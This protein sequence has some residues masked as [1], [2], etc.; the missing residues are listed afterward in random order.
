MKTLRARAKKVCLVGRYG[1]GETGDEAA[2]AGL[3]QAFRSTPGGGESDL[4]LT[5]LSG[6]P[7]TTQAEHDIRALHRCRLDAVAAS[8]L[9]ATGA[10]NVFSDNDKTHSLFYCL[11]LMRAAQILGKH[12]MIAAA[13]IGP[14]KRQSSAA[15]LAS[16]ARGC[17]AITVTDESSSEALAK[18]GVQTPA[19]LVAADPAILLGSGAPGHSVHGAS[20]SLQ[21][22]PDAPEDFA[23][24][25][26]RICA[27]TLEL[28]AYQPMPMDS[29]DSAVIDQF[30]E[31]ANRIFGYERPL[32]LRTDPLSWQDLRQ[33][34]AGSGLVIAMRLHALIL[35]A[36]SGVPSVA[37]DHDPKVRAF[38]QLSGQTDTVVCLREV[39]ADGFRNAL[40]QAWDRKEETATRL[41]DL[42]PSLCRSARRTAEIAVSAMNR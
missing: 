15:L 36:A 10:G 33:R 4:R 27:A 20:I 7:K 40:A 8:D 11:G 24:V 17:D 6:R 13:G 41:R 21:Q 39:Y 25:I 12:T 35:A 26:G 37:L 38:M 5:A 29:R 3:V 9:V 19:P 18:I 32:K 22:W 14:L 2:L 1:V 23:K 30:N 31:A 42:L 34:T 28:R 16:V